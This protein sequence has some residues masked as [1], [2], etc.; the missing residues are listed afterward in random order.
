[1]DLNS[2]SDTCIDTVDCASVWTG[3]VDEANERNVIWTGNNEKVQ[4]ENLAQN[5]PNDYEENE[6]CIRLLVNGKWSNYNY[7]CDAKMTFICEKTVNK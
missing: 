7:N 6:H 2:F 1:M 4:S 5:N 3:R